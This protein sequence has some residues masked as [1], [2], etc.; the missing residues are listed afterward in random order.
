M[1]L[2]QH[3]KTVVT[4]G[5]RQPNTKHWRSNMKP[6]KEELPEP[7]IE[8]IIELL[9]AMAAEEYG[10]K[11]A[12]IYVEGGSFEAYQETIPQA[13]KRLLED[14][15]RATVVWVSLEDAELLRYPFLDVEFNVKKGAQKIGVTGP[16]AKV[17]EVMQLI[18]GV[19]R[20]RP[21]EE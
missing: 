13:S 18:G 20:L 8:S 2:E 14:Q 12:V 3:T 4:V 21:Q 17:A 15:L 6:L 9:E 10:A 11:L 5:R 19:P 7:K 16:P 1:Y